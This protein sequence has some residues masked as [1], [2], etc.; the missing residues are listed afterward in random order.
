MEQGAEIPPVG[1]QGEAPAE[2]QTLS[3]NG[4]SLLAS[5][6]GVSLPSKS[7]VQPPAAGK[8]LLKR[9]PISS[10]LDLPSHKKP[11]IAEKSVL[12][13]AIAREILKQKRSGLV[14]SASDSDIYDDVVSYR[15][16][17]SQADGDSALSQEDTYDDIISVLASS[18]DN[19]IYDDIITL[20]AS[21]DEDEVYDDV[22]SVLAASGEA[23]Y[24]NTAGLLQHVDTEGQLGKAE[25]RIKPTKPVKPAWLLKPTKPVQPAWLLK[26]PKP[27][28]PA[29]LSKVVKHV[30]RR[31]SFGDIYDDVVVKQ[32]REKLAVK[33]KP[34]LAEKPVGLHQHPKVRELLEQLRERRSESK[35]GDEGKVRHQSPDLTGGQ[36]LDSRPENPPLISVA[37]VLGNGKI[38]PHQEDKQPTTGGVIMFPLPVSQ[39]QRKDDHSHQLQPPGAGEKA[40]DVYL[41][42]LPPSPVPAHKKTTTPRPVEKEDVY[43][44][45]LPPSPVPAH[46]RVGISKPEGVVQQQPEEASG[47]WQ[48][49]QSSPTKTEESTYE[50]ESVLGGRLI[51]YR[52]HR[53]PKFN[54]RSLSRD[55][56]SPPDKQRTKAS[57]SDS[58][59]SASGSRPKLQR[60]QSYNITCPQST[61]G[62]EA[63]DSPP[64]ASPILTNRR[65]Y[66]PL[67]DIEEARPHYV[68][69][70]ASLRA[71]ESIAEE[72]DT[73]EYLQL[74]ED[75]YQ[76]QDE[77]EG[78]QDLDHAVTEALGLPQNMRERVQRITRH[79]RNKL[80]KTVKHTRRK[81]QRSQTMPASDF[82]TR[83]TRVGASVE[84]RTSSAPSQCSGEAEKT[85]KANGGSEE[86]GGLSRTRGGGATAGE[87]SPQGDRQGDSSAEEEED[88]IPFGKS[89][90]VF[91]MLLD[92]SG[93]QRAREA[94]NP[95]ELPIEPSTSDDESVESRDASA[96][97]P[98]P[99]ALSSPFFDS[100]ELD[101]IYDTPELR[102]Y[103]EAGIIQP[104]SK[105]E[106]D[107]EIRR[108]TSTAPAEPPP[109]PGYTRPRTRVMT[110]TDKVLHKRFLMKRRQRLL[111]TSAVVNQAEGSKCAPPPPSFVPPPPLMA[112]P[113]PSHR[114][115]TSP[116]STGLAP[117]FAPPTNPPAAAQAASS[118]HDSEITYQ[119]LPRTMETQATAV[120]TT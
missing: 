49:L 90:V 14:R 43:L 82:G 102:S 4:C 110:R 3:A 99:E 16:A 19:G 13:L 100:Q 53:S 58:S 37:G 93:I 45:L 78:Y 26:P 108:I 106:L 12:V 36:S 41:N 46:R 64:S 77:G 80:Q 2:S 54:F 86:N 81:I 116:P 29:W 55:G 24:D 20:M 74:Y 34:P 33:N 84:S 50:N 56:D 28:K 57:S 94:S 104:R 75:L 66:D 23:L 76:Y 15:T 101:K 39:Q 30:P 68:E 117:P 48:A 115:V 60:A 27:A 85:R 87:G 17:H 62:Y 18:E 72:A 63:L 113:P 47:P 71:P 21:S 109:L 32:V 52:E 1:V 105:T 73:Y 79:Q 118:D 67:P 51:Q 59:R 8:S 88:S 11:A 91:E 98:K 10:H 97:P 114:S 103:Q 89:R 107:E 111:N 112:T 5:S 35:T 119:N 31:H 95:L 120:G 70:L 9:H 61:D 7:A 22:I 25:S 83:H 42:L 96:L 38:T 6:K 65:K 92:A 44:N 40:E 69:Y